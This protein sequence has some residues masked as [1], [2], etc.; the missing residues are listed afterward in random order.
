MPDVGIDRPAGCRRCPASGR[1]RSG[2]GRCRLRTSRVARHRRHLVVAADHPEAPVALVRTRPGSAA[3]RATARPGARATRRGRGGRSRR[4]PARPWSRPPPARPVST[5]GRRRSRARGPAPGR[6]RPP[7]PPSRSP[8]ASTVAGA[9][10]LERRAR[11]R[12]RLLDAQAEPVGQRGAREGLARRRPGV[13]QV[14]AGGL[15]PAAMTASRHPGSGGPVSLGPRGRRSPR[16]SGRSRP[17]SPGRRLRGSRTTS[18]GLDGG[19]RRSP[20][21]MLRTGGPR[22]RGTVRRRRR[23]PPGRR[24]RGLARR[25]GAQRAASMARRPPPAM[26]AAAAMRSTSA[27]SSGVR[28]SQERPLP[29]TSSAPGATAASSGE[30]GLDEVVPIRRA[31]QPGMAATTPRWLAGFHDSPNR[32]SWPTSGGTPSSQ[33]ER[34]WGARCRAPPRR[35]GRRAAPRPSTASARPWRRPPRPAAP[36]RGR[37]GG[38]V[39]GRE[40]PA[41]A[42]GP[43]ARVVDATTGR[44]RLHGSPNGSWGVAERHPAVVGDGDDVLGPVAGGPVVPDHRLQDQ[45]H[46]RRQHQLVEVVAQVGTDHR[47]L[48]AVGADPVG[49]V[50][51]LDPGSARRCSR[52]ASASMAAPAQLPASSCPACTG[53]DAS[54]T[55]RQ[56]ANCSC[57]RRRAGRRRRSTSARSPRRTRRRGRPCRPRSRRRRR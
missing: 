24:P 22:R 55:A 50:E 44:R 32:S 2:S 6:R 20:D 42:V 57:W 26:P 36:A 11:G 40:Q 12:R 9:S 43:H 28:A 38:A 54:T 8:T 7:R 53:A 31:R 48:G 51:V 49:Q 18:A 15:G 30:A 56:R 52:P 25:A 16:G 5:R 10:T 45:D 1:R 23:S 4:S 46:A 19:R 13:D 39:H 17:R 35:P 3:G 47:H 27:G 33:T 34:R 21:P 37:R 41:A 14:G 29:S